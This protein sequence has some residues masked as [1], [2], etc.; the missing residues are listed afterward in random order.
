MNDAACEL[1]LGYRV[2]VRVRGVITQSFRNP[3]VVSISLNMVG[4]I[5]LEPTTPTMSRWCSNQLSYAPVGD[6]L[7]G[8]RA[9]H[10]ILR[11]FSFRAGLCEKDRQPLVGVGSIP[12]CNTGKSPM[13]GG[14][15]TLREFAIGDRNVVPRSRAGNMGTPG[16]QLRLYVVEDSAILLRRLLDL[17]EGVGLYVVG[18]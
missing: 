6:E 3:V 11:W 13:Y 5:G 8:K 2:S 7:Y 10:P 14:G 12:T 1:A 18:H 4:A 17:L 16:R 9:P 15:P